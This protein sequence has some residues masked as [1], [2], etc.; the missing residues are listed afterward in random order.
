LLQELGGLARAITDYKVAPRGIRLAG[1]AA[2]VQYKIL[3]NQLLFVTSSYGLLGAMCD[4]FKD[5]YKVLA[6]GFASGFG[7]GR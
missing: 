7:R 3:H 2:G 4:S 1:H 5:S 6:E